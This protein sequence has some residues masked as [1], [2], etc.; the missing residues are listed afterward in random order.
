MP[1]HIFVST[2]VGSSFDVLDL[3]KNLKD[4]VALFG[5]GLLLVGTGWRRLRWFV[6]DKLLLLVAAYVGLS[7]LLVIFRPIDQDAELLGLVYNLR[8][9]M[10]FVYA[11]ILT[12]VD[13][14]LVVRVVKIV[15]ASSAVVSLLA[16]IQYLVLPDDFLTNFGYSRQNGVLPAFFIDNKP[17]Y[18]RVMSTLRD[19]N[20]LGSYLLLPFSFGFLALFRKRPNTKLWAGITGLVA[21]ALVL[22]FSRSAWIGALTVGLVIVLSDP[23]SRHAA[24][25]FLRRRWPL[26]LGV[27]LVLV[28]LL[29][30]SWR[31]SAVQNL[32]FHA[33]QQTVLEDPNQIRSRVY[34][35]SL[36]A[37]IDKPEGHGI[38]TAGLAS[39]RN[40]IQ[41]TFLN[42]NYYLQIAYETGWIGFGLFITILVFSF[43]KIWRHQNTFIGVALVASF[44]GLLLTNF[45][46]HIWSN[47]AVAYTWW[48]LA[49]LVAYSGLSRSASSDITAE[50]SR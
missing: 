35:E 15:A 5:F 46:V 3:A 44:T 27:L 37:I 25:A 31:S 20:S 38:G 12:R 26:L 22:T 49:G 1:F 14:G 45:L 34:S 13:R 10:M 47:E 30:A 18:Q 28:S 40:D 7:L 23:V 39:I 43:K 32:V 24:S 6:S 36:E 16:L 29:A 9:L 21:L 41:G 4:T 33:D 50:S 42:E 48:G 8:F 11:A 17:E 19:P 2:W